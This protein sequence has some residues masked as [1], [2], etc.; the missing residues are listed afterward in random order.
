MISKARIKELYTDK[1]YQTYFDVGLF[2]VLIL[3]IHFIY[4]PWDKAHYWPI[5]DQVMTLFDRASALLFAQSC[6][7][8]NLLNVD[9][10]TYKQSIFA[11]NCNNVYSSVTV[12]PDCTSLKQWIHW[13]VL[14]LAFPGP[15]KHKAWY[16]PVGLIIIELTNVIRIVGL[17]LIQ[18]PF[19]NSFH[20]AHDYIFKTLFYFVIFVMWVVWVEKFVHPKKKNL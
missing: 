3:G 14:M 1:R 17:L 8:L 7:V 5:T 4:V 12:A 11:L 16:I 15:W 6:R 9:I 2:A 10:T 20:F 19:P 18:L 13:M